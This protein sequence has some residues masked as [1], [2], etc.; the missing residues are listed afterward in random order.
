MLALGHYAWGGTLLLVAA[1]F[2]V[3]AI[4]ILPHMWTGTVLTNLPTALMFAASAA[5]PFAALGGSL[6]A[7]GRRAWTGHAPLCPALCWTHGVLLLRGAFAIVIGLQGMR[8]A[9]ASAA[10]G[11][12]IMGSLAAL[13]L[14]FGGAILA[15]S[16][17]SL[18]VALLVLRDL[19]PE[20]P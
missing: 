3:G 6:L 7:L 20:A 11:G 4:R 14:L 17:P 10:R 12:G 19:R 1:W 13:P 5:G 2:G 18:A 9:E 15:L 16:V 8:Q